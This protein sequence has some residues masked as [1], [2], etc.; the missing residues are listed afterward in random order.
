MFDFQLKV[1]YIILYIFLDAE[2]DNKSGSEQDDL[3]P[4]TYYDN[5]VINEDDEEALKMFMASRPEKTRTLADII[6]DKITEKNTELQ[7][8]FSD[9]ETLKLQNIDPRYVFKNH[10]FNINITQ[11]LYLVILIKV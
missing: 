7:T 1:I 10:S 3:E 11:I 9:V 6:R 8:Q 5:I 2:S 4:D